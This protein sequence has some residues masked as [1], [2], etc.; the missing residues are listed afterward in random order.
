MEHHHLTQLW[1]QGVSLTRLN[2]LYVVRL[3]NLSPGKYK[4]VLYVAREV[5]NKDGSLRLGG[6]SDRSLT[7]ADS[8]DEP[9]LKTIRNLVSNITFGKLGRLEMEFRF[10]LSQKEKTVFS[11]TTK[12]ALF[13]ETEIEFEVEGEPPALGYLTISSTSTV[14]SLFASCF[15]F[16]NDGSLSVPCR[17]VDTCVSDEVEKQHAGHQNVFYLLPLL[18]FAWGLEGGSLLMPLLI[19]STAYLIENGLV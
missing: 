10:K 3:C 5:D 4:L 1:R 19:I 15:L 6:S 2:A 13:E 11:K 16:R 17:S 7:H 8:A 18:G 12:V 14:T 9:A